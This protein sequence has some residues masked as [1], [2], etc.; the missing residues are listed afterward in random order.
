M[1]GRPL[2]SVGARRQLRLPLRPVLCC[3]VCA[4]PWPCA[5]ARL[6]LTVSFRHQRIA[7]MLYLGTQFVDAISDLHVYDSALGPPPDVRAIFDRIMCW[8]PPDRPPA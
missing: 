7:L 3:R 5:D 6:D 4:Q 2:V 8:M 1:T